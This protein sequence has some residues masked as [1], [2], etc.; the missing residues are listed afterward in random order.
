MMI[1]PR[2][3][4]RGVS[5]LLAIAIAFSAGVTATGWMHDERLDTADLALEK[6]YVLLQASESG[7]VDIRV[8]REFDRHIRKALSAIEGA[9]D[10]TAAAAAAADGGK[11]APASGTLPK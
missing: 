3:S 7:A 9:R 8:Q 11:A 4:A 5:L 2:L 6:A 10:A 1:R